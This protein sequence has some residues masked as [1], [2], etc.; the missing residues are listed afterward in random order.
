MER[1]TERSLAAGL[2]LEVPREHAAKV[3]EMGMAVEKRPVDAPSANGG[4]DV[5]AAAQKSGAAADNGAEDGAE[6]SA[7]DGALKVRHRS[8][9]ARGNLHLKNLCRSPALA[10]K[11][12]SNSAA[13]AAQDCVAHTHSNMALRMACMTAH[14]QATLGQ[15]KAKLPRLLATSRFWRHDAHYALPSF[16]SLSTSTRGYRVCH[17]HLR[18][19]YLPYVKACVVPPITN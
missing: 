16:I 7:Q 12:G 19:G 8:C 15:R 10:M 3:A 9:K 2:E 14:Q 4:G 5:A 6:D 17:P 13:A 1:L 11:G 18:T